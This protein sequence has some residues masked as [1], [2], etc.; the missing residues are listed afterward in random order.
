[1]YLNHAGSSYLYDI[2]YKPFIIFTFY[3]PTVYNIHTSIPIVAI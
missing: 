1:M 2:G 3:V